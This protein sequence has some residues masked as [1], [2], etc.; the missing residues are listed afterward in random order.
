MVSQAN[1]VKQILREKLRLLLEGHGATDFGKLY[2]VLELAKQGFNKRILAQTLRHMAEDK[3]VKREGQMVWWIAKPVP[4]GSIQ[5]YRDDAEA[6]Q[7]MRNQRME[8]PPSIREPRS[9]KLPDYQAQRQGFLVT[10]ETAPDEFPNVVQLQVKIG[11]QWFNQPVK[12]DVRICTGERIPK[13]TPAQELNRG[14][15]AI[16]FVYADESYDTRDINPN[17]SVVIALV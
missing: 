12:G 14:I 2:D 5:P 1:Q 16:R 17:E 10:L 15:S 7:H 13:F 6:P 8:P 3:L 11:G 9:I 4:N